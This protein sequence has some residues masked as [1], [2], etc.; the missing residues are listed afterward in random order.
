LRISKVPDP[1]LLQAKTMNW[2]KNLNGLIHNSLAAL[3]LAGAAT[4][5]LASA[6]AARDEKEAPSK[7]AL[8]KA[9]EALLSNPDRP[10]TGLSV[11]VVK[12][13]KIVYDGNFGKRKIDPENPD[14]SLPVDRD[15]KFRVASISKLET[16]T[17]IMQLLEQKKIDLDEDISRYLSFP[18]RNPNFPDTPITVRML[19]SHTSSIRDCDNYVFPPSE[20]LKDLFVAGGK[21][22]DNGAHFAPAIKEHDQAPGKFFAYSNLGYGLLGTIVEAVSGERFDKYMR[23]HVLLPLGCKASYNV[24]DFSKAELNEVSVLYRKMDNNEKWDP[25]GP[26]YSQFDEYKDGVA[27]LPEGADKYIPGTNATWISPQGGLRISA[28]DLSRIMRMFMNGGEFNGVRILKPETVSLMF[29]P[30]WTYDKAKGNGETD[31]DL[32]VCYGLGPQI[33]TN[34][35][36]DRLLEKTN[37]EMKG[38][39]G[40]ANGLL[41]CMMMDFKNKNGFILI[42]GGVGA[43]PDKNMGSYSSFYKWEEEIATAIF[44]N[45]L[46]DY[47]Y[48]YTNS[49]ALS[50]STPR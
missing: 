30:Q 38:H 21:H 11:V 35:F 22:W 9:L 19:L 27:K 18:V 44:Q 13:G 26:W 49:T 1:L 2:N 14:K 36:G 48:T 8:G 16:A 41:S 47:T 3:L 20:S 6:S 23:A 28:L 34:K 46:S 15:T 7:N 37:V 39:I 29:S 5:L 45:V 32:M 33:L 43:N 25:Q 4:V 42:M 40:D 10:L 50:G 24:Q 17:A 12:H 31:R